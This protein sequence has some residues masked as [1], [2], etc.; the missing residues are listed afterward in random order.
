MA[1]HHRC[2]NEFRGDSFLASRGPQIRTSS[3]LPT[4]PTLRTSAVSKNSNVQIFLEEKTL[5]QGR[6]PILDTIQDTFGLNLNSNEIDEWKSPMATESAA[7]LTPYT[8]KNDFCSSLEYPVSNH[9]NN[10]R[11]P[12]QNCLFLSPSLNYIIKMDIWRG[13]CVNFFSCLG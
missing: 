1:E 2:Q 8:K 3:R 12:N 11:T 6:I 5:T 10:K 13:T 9:A 7:T 4:R